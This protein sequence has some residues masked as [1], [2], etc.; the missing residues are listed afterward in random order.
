MLSCACLGRE[1]NGAGSVDE[2]DEGPTSSGPANPYQQRSLVLRNA[3]LI[4]ANGGYA[5]SVSLL[6]SLG[7]SV[8]FFEIAT[9]F[10]PLH[11]AAAVGS[12]SCCGE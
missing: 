3:L 5:R 1:S 6:V 4:A 2:N 11:Y 12:K 7:A 9:G 8:D 10:G